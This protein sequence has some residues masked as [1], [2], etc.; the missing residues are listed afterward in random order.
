MPSHFVTTALPTHHAPHTTHPAPPRP[1][2]VA[3]IL[4]DG[5]TCF[6]GGALASPDKPLAYIKMLTLKE[7][8]DSHQRVKLAADLGEILA[9]RGIGTAGQ[10]V[11][12]QE[13]DDQ[14]MAIKGKLLNPPAVVSS[15]RGRRDTVIAGHVVDEKQLKRLRI[16]VVAL[17]VL[18]S[19]LL[20]RKTMI[21]GS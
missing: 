1:R 15:G 10:Q 18:S 3:I 6:S 17:S 16:G 4:L 21:R 5:L 19:L 7:Q 9:A 20:C 2:F 11:S 12:F 14:H 8:L 13:V